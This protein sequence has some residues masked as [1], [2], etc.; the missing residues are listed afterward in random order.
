MARKRFTDAD[1]WED[2]WFCGLPPAIKLFWNYICD[3]CDHGGVW[4]IN[5]PLA[6]FHMGE[7]D[8][9]AIERALSRR[10][11]PVRG[12]S[13]W[14]IPGFI[15]F[16]YPSGL[17]L[18]SPAHKRI[19]ATLT[20]HG[21]NPDTLSYTVQGTVSDT[22]E[23][24]DEDKDKDSSSNAENPFDDESMAKAKA[25]MAADAV[26]KPPLPMPPK[27]FADFR[28]MHSRV[29]VG[30]EERQEWEAL[31]RLYGWDALHDMHTHLTADKI[32]YSVANDWLSREYELKEQK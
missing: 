3:Q 9:A 14:F 10:V 11:V 16:Q 7:L 6:Q 17:S 28:A 8:Q 26:P 5:W 19:R 31:Y 32:F 21:I 13:R 15:R 18:T 12:G 1:K 2:A 30:R 27:S 22:P 29:F 4:D 20:G 24:K 25:I 23:D